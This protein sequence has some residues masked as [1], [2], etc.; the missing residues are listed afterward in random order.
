MKSSLVKLWKLAHRPKCD[1]VSR[2]SM[3]GTRSCVG[4]EDS[5]VDDDSPDRWERQLSES[6]ELLT[7]LDE[8]VEPVARRAV[9]AALSA[10]GGALDEL[11]RF[12]EAVAV[13]DKIVRRFAVESLEEPPR[14]VFRALLKK[15]L[16][17]VRLAEPT[18]AIETVGTL[19]AL[20]RSATQT[21]R[22]RHLTAAALRVNLAAVGPG[23]P[24][25]S[26][27]VDEDLITRFADSDDARLHQQVTEALQRKA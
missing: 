1:A 12:A 3:A 19:L 15:A 13:W 22:M 5:A 11:G 25:Q 24:E 21:D 4:C 17:L 20:S 6:D 14:V 16:D 26:I 18:E 7:R 2:G 27:A 8:S 9:A 10:K 23:K